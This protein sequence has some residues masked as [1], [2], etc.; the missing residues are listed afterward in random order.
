MS[1]SDAPRSNFNFPTGYR[2]GAGRATAE[3]ASACRDFGFSRPLVVTDPG[4]RGLP[5]FEPLLASLAGLEPG[6]WSDCAGNPT[7]AHVASALAAYK[8]GKHD[9]IVL[10]G[11]GSA[12]DIEGG[13]SSTTAS[14]R[15]AAFTWRSAGS[16]AYSRSAA[17]L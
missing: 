2:I 17:Y 4:V 3:L 11:G 13:Y 15:L 16:G 12:M 1:P 8:A 10:V 14:S 9:G 7:E 5:W 6:V